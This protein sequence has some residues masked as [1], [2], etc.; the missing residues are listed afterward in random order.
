MIFF[1]IIYYY[2]ATCTITVIFISTSTFF[3]IITTIIIL[4]ITPNIILYIVIIPHITIIIGSM[5]KIIIFIAFTPIF[6][7]L[8][9]IVSTQ[10]LN[11]FILNHF[12]HLI[13][14]I[15]PNDFLLTIKTLP[16]V[17]DQLTT[18]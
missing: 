16:T 8:I 4:I 3:Y 7:T 2:F 1:I 17:W 13:Q 14:N 15:S 18:L 10:K 11:S 12:L 5:G 9:K 6:I